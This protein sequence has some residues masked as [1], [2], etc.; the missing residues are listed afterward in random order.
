MGI[1]LSSRGLGSYSSWDAELFRSSPENPTASFRGSRE[2]ESNLHRGD[3]RL[4]FWPPGTRGLETHARN[5]IANGG[6]E[7][8]VRRVYHRQCGHHGSASRV[9]VEADAN[10]AS[11][12]RKLKWITGS[13]HGADQAWEHT[14]AA[15][16]EVVEVRALRLR[17]AECRLDR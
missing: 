13:R 4:G 10:L 1:G 6:R 16:V 7:Q 12:I 14:H 2:T 15:Q 3:Y 17:R 11:L 9:H 8:R 5:Y